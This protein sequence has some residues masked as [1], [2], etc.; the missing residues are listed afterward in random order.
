MRVKPAPG[1]YV[2]ESG[3]DPATV[4]IT[5]DGATIGTVIKFWGLEFS[6]LLHWEWFDLSGGPALMP[7]GGAP[8]Y[9]G[10]DDNGTGAVVYPDGSG[11]EF[12][13]APA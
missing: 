4:E 7:V 12:R 3:G 5:P 10:F 6:T 2:I 13:Y 1:P 11:A 8:G 9:I